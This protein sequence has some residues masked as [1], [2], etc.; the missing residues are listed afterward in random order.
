[1]PRKTT[2]TEDQVLTGGGTRDRLIGGS[3]N[4]SLS[5][6]GGADA[7]T[8]GLGAD[9]LNGG[10]GADTFNI[11][12]LSDTMAGLD[13]VMDYTAGEDTISFDRHLRLDEYTFASFVEA[14]YTAA[15]ASANLACATGA[16]VVAV[17][18]GSDLILFADTDRVDGPDAAV[19]L[20]GRSLDGLQVGDIN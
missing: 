1:M 7:L 15:L 5:G 4:D 8:G 19:V 6:G 20:V 3:G 17:Q 9:T 10:D 12:G 16:K 14:D 13:Q 18:V 2:I 11:T